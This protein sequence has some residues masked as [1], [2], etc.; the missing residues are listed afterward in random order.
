AGELRR[1]DAPVADAAFFVRALDTQ[2]HRPHRPR[3]RRRALVWWL[4]QQLELMDGDRALAMAGAEAVGA[5]VTTADDDDLLAGGD[6]LVR[7][8]AP[9]AGLVRLR[10]DL[11]RE[12]NPA[13]LTAR[14]VEVARLLGAACQEDCVELLAQALDRDV[15][16][17]MRLGLKLHSL[18]SHLLDA[19][20]DEVL[21]Q[22][23][24][25]DAVAQQSADA[26]GLLQDRD[27]VAGARQLL[28]G[29]ESCRSGA[30]HRNTLAGPRLGRFR[31]HDSGFERA[32]DD[33]LLDALDRDRRFVAAPHTSGRAGRGRKAA[34]EFGE[35]V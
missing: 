10:E 34:A 31:T 19:P 13:E 18:G 25:G 14:N 11:H 8:F 1:V 27:I 29:G 12:V 3:R 2:L 7:S 4:G 22:L 23:E 16:A 35:V 9:L 32:I 20:V 28:R 33:R 15:G 21:L 5:G 17:D 6:D 24:V 26:V 30:D